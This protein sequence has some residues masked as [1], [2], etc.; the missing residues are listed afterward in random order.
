[1]QVIDNINTLFG[2]EL[3]SSLTANSKLKVAA[4]CFSMY[5]FV[6]LKKELLKIDSLEF[7][8][9]SPTFVPEQATDKIKKEHC[10]FYIPKINRER[11]VFGSEFEIHLKNELNQKAIAQECACWIKNKVTFKSNTSN[12]HMQPFAA[13]ESKSGDT[14]YAP[15]NGFT[16]VDLGYQKGSAVSNFVHKFDQMPFTAQYLQLFDQIWNDP[17]KRKVTILQKMLT[18]NNKPISQLT[19]D[20]GIAQGTLYSWRA[21]AR[22]QGQLMPDGDSTPQGWGE[23]DKFAAVLETSALNET[24]LSVYFRKKGLHTQ[25]I[26]EW[27]ARASKLTTGIALKVNDYKRTFEALI[28]GLKR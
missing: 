16:A 19:K 5:A 3:K 15:I 22:A 27:R 1:M 21:A 7:I 13:C 25:Q 10:E 24:A 11:S 9:T 23:S 20:E 4:S 2:E 17:A 6:A 28:S 8:F 26:K 14:V 12:A 18:P